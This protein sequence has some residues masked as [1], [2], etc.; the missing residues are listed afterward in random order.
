MSAP[1][2][3]KS[4][5]S[6]SLPRSYE[7]RFQSLDIFTGDGMIDN[8]M[9]EPDFFGIRPTQELTEYFGSRTTWHENPSQKKGSKFTY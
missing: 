1:L 5:R 6:S 3:K 8:V 4:K 7:T 9:P 2:V